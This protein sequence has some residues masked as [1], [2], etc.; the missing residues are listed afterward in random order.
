[1]AERCADGKILGQIPVCQ[2]CGGGK[3]RFNSKTGIYTCPG[4]MDDD[5]FRHCNAS[6]NMDE[7]KRNPWV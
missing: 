1:M 3:P 6:S 2:H 4:Y 5:E 7:V